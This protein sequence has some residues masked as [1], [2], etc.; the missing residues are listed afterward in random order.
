MPATS[1]TP[2][3]SYRG[4]PA[5]QRRAERR[6]R[7]LDAALERLGT[8][9]WSKTT[10]RGVCE[11]A[12]LN[13]RYFYESFEDLD[14]LL[15]A[16][17]DEGVVEATEVILAAYAAAP[18]DGHAK[19]EATVGAFVRYATDDPRR[20]RIGFVE[21]LGNQALARRRLEAMHAMSQLVAAYARDF[22]G[23]ADDP[24]PISD[25]AASM[26]VGGVSELMITWLDGRLH[27]TREQLVEDITELFVITGEGAIAIARARNKRT[28]A[29]T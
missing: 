10:V 7:L 28:G 4:A 3:R 25:I 15:L 14:A 13:P 27:V 1:K 11:E 9:G 24:D 23:V 2:T 22:Y 19:A 12:R 29:A 20:A 16:L 5:E 18:D 17:F 26:I 8:E 6:R 21:A